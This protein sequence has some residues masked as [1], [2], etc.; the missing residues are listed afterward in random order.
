MKR[1]CIL[2]LTLLMAGSMLMSCILTGEQSRRA[3]IRGKWQP[4]MSKREIY[5][6]NGGHEI[7]IDSTFSNNDLMQ[8]N[9]DGSI[10]DGGQR[11]SSYRLEP[12]NKTLR[13]FGDNDDGKRFEIDKLD[14][15]TLVLAIRI[16]ESHA[17]NNIRMEWT[18]SFVRK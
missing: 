5:D 2:L 1:S 14:T 8:F 9:A 4:V 7:K 11:Y 16:A 10:V 17:G 18:I 13:L 12:D 3:L 15:K 6:F